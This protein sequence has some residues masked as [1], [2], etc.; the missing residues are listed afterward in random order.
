MNA[1]EVE[2]PEQP[3]LGGEAMGTA[4][5][6]ES[7]E[8]PGEYEHQEQEEVFDDNQEKIYAHQEGDMQDP[9][10]ENYGDGQDD[11]QQ[12]GYPEEQYQAMYQQQ[13]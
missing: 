8:Q 2:S 5:G 3:T 7:P 9:N 11:V 10:Q 6:E 1:Q 4:E 13:Q 12:Y